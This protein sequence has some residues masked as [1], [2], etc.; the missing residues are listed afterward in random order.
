MVHDVCNPNKEG[1]TPVIVMVLN[2]VYASME[3]NLVFSTGAANAIIVTITYHC[4]VGPPT[5]YMT[6]AHDR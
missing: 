2:T 5:Y 4:N 3:E 6:Y 1:G